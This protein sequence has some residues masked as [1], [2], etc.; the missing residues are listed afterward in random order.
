V[1]VAFGNSDTVTIVEIAPED[2]DCTR[3]NTQFR[4][5]AHVR[6]GGV[7]GDPLWLD[8][9]K[10]PRL[11][12]MIEG[13]T[14]KLWA[15]EATQAELE[16]SEVTVFGDGVALVSNNAFCADCITTVPPGMP[17]ICDIAK[18]SSGMKG[19]T[20][21]KHRV[22]IDP[23]VTGPVLQSENLIV[24]GSHSIASRTCALRGVAKFKKV[25]GDWSAQIDPN[26]RD[27]QVN[28]P[29]CFPLNTIIFL[30]SMVHSQEGPIVHAVAIQI[31]PHGAIR[32]ITDVTAPEEEVLV[33]LDG[34]V[35][36]PSMAAPKPPAP[37]CVPYCF[38]ETALKSDEMSPGTSC[39]KYCTPEQLDPSTFPRMPLPCQC[40][41]LKRIDCWNHNATD[42]GES[43][44][45]R[46]GQYKQLLA[47]RHK[48]VP[49]GN[50]MQREEWIQQK[51]AAICARQLSA[52]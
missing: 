10:Q 20:V 24:M 35:Y 14:L 37:E 44:G 19:C 39:V 17:E 9:N 5:A 34:I 41:M 23:A 12:L 36:H 51:C 7:T 8:E 43:S 2:N 15:N 38:P 32:M 50:A 40:D 13:Q 33:R 18:Q 49:D 6:K 47:K 30:A 45:I 48:E 4:V 11:Q 3:G 26:L 22:L 31:E 21:T 1:T 28:A 27:P 46:C 16:N 29:L 52:F 42:N 25:N